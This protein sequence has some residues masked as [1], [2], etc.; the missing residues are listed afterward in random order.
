MEKVNKA[1]DRINLACQPCRDIE[2]IAVLLSHFLEAFKLGRELIGIEDSAGRG[3]LSFFVRHIIQLV[4]QHFFKFLIDLFFHFTASAFEA[5]DQILQRDNGIIFFHETTDIVD[6][7]ADIALFQLAD[8][9]NGFPAFPR[10]VALLFPLI[11]ESVIVRF[12]GDVIVLG[13]NAVEGALLHNSPLLV[14]DADVEKIA[15]A[16]VDA[17]HVAAASGAERLPHAAIQLRRLYFLGGVVQRNGNMKLK[18]RLG[19]AFVFDKII[20]KN[21]CFLRVVRVLVFDRDAG[22]MNGGILSTQTCFTVEHLR[23]TI[24]R[25]GGVSQ[26]FPAEQRFEI[27]RMK[28]GRPL[29][30]LGHIL[31]VDLEKA[32]IACLYHSVQPRPAERAGNNPVAPF[33]KVTVKLIHRAV[34]RRVLQPGQ[35]KFPEGFMPR[36]AKLVIVD[37]FLNRLRITLG[38]LPLFLRF[39][40]P[41]IVDFQ[42]IRHGEIILRY[43]G[44]KV[45]PLGADEKTREVLRVHFLHLVFKVCP[46]SICGSEQTV[47]LRLFQRPVQHGKIVRRPVGKEE[48]VVG[49]PVHRPAAQERG[50]VEVDLDLVLRIRLLRSII[51]HL[52]IQRRD[53]VERVIQRRKRTVKQIILIL[54]LPRSG[55]YFRKALEILNGVQQVLQLLNAHIVGDQL[56]LLRIRSGKQRHCRGVCRI[57]R[58]VQGGGGVRYVCGQLRRR[59]IFRRGKSGGFLKLRKGITF[60]RR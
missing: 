41:V 29:A 16:A 35:I 43:G 31:A 4:N 11:K 21:A 14:N 36:D 52:V 48:A 7:A 45:V 37:H 18:L 30:V 27:K 9:L 39:E 44:R 60:P 12:A 51:P 13:N 1:G 6:H 32:H 59:G 3:F 28:I 8:R 22:G 56:L 57:R 17:D 47:R 42:Y 25:N 46:A 20:R 34:C 2:Q 10:S 5:V 58:A 40:P 55:E 38:V 15:F 49:G 54:F 23:A 19:I 53:R 26:I 24:E 33:L 50:T